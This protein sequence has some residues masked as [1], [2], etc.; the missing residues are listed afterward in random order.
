MLTKRA[1]SESPPA[2]DSPVSSMTKQD[3]INEGEKNSDLLQKSLKKRRFDW[4][5]NLFVNEFV[6]FDDG[7]PP[8]TILEKR[9]IA[10]PIP[11]IFIP[12]CQLL[13]LQNV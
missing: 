2:H 3:G 13:W 9:H 6:V 11:H 4:R 1:G 5:W 8:L 10:V 7:H 12:S